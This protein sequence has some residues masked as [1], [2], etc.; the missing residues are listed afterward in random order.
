MKAFPQLL[1]IGI[2]ESTAIVVIKDE[3]EVIGKSYV[4]IY[5]TSDVPFFFLKDG[6]KY[7]LK[8]HKIIR[9]EKKTQ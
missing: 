9:A 1:G 4:A 7:D 6:Q 3:F 8:K 2:D 5:G